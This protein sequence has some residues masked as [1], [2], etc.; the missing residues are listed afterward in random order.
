MRRPA[1]VVLAAAL[2]AVATTTAV[3]V[4][5]REDGARRSGGPLACGDCGRT[6]YGIPMRLGQPA[7]FGILTLQN[8]GLRPAILE[9]IHLLDA[10]PALDVIDMLVVEPDGSSPLIA[11]DTG[12]PPPSPGGT[13]FRVAGYAVAPSSGPPDFVQVLIVA[14][15]RKRGM[16]GGRG[17]AVDYRVNGRRYRAVYPYSIWLCTHGD[18]PKRRCGSTDY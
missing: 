4:S 18:E 10:D 15:I 13:T 1:V 14:T 2:V 9:A 6:A 7:S 8:T 11:V 17:L 3:Y 12:L 5:H 16:A